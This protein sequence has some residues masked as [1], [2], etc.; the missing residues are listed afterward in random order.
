[1]IYTVIHNLAAHNKKFTLRHLLSLFQYGSSFNRIYI[2]TTYTSPYRNHHRQPWRSTDNF[3][4]LWPMIHKLKKYSSIVNVFYTSFFH[5]SGGFLC[6]AKP[7]YDGYM[8]RKL[9]QR[10]KSTKVPLLIISE[11]FIFVAYYCIS[12]LWK[13]DTFSDTRLLGVTNTWSRD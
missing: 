12:C 1:M 4:I 2:D 13:L 3:K 5:V 10:G 11:Y 6:L 8:H 7:R 9:L